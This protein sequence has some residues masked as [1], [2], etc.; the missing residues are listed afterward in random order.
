MILSIRFFSTSTAMRSGSRCRAARTRC[1]CRKGP[2]YRRHQPAGPGLCGDRAQPLCA[3]RDP[4]HRYCGGARD[5]RRARDLHRGRPRSRRASARCRRGSHEQSRRHADAE[6]GAARAG[7]RQGALCRRSG[8]LPS[9]PRPWPQAKD[10]A[11]AVRRRHRAAARGYRPRARRRRPARRSSTTTCP[12]MSALDFHYG[13]SEK[14][15]PPS[16]APPMS[17]GSSCATTASSSTRWSRAPRLREYDA[18]RGRWTLHVG[19]PGRV[20]AAQLARR[21]ALASGATRCAC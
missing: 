5:A 6:P 20:R 16:P 7:D 9:S 13:D 19:S 11:E 12:A 4:R 1:W 21:C 2:I 3:W 14:A 17:R 18:E 10:A 8:R 15:R